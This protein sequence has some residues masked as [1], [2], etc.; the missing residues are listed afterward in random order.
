MIVT[1]QERFTVVIKRMI[2]IMRMIMTQ[3]EHCTRLASSF[4]IRCTIRTSRWGAP[5][6]EKNMFRAFSSSLF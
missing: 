3:Q 5:L 4:Y 1:R 2:M 6:P